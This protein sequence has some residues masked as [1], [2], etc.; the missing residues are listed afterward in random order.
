MKF[1]QKWFQEQGFDGFQSISRLSE[2]SESIPKERGVYALLI[3]TGSEPSFN[4]LGTGGHF[5][6]RNPNVSLKTL[7]SNWVR[8]TSTLYIGKAGGTGSSATL[9]SR[10]KQYLKFGQGKPV[11][12]WGGRLVWQI[13]VASEILIC[14]KVIKD[15][16]PRN[17]E[18]ELLNEFV[19]IY[20]KL[21][22]A[23]L[24]M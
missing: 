12:H 5:K 18:K 7:E 16:E 19:L 8:N 22:Y 20:G 4:E 21:P 1:D 24:T 6:G 2:S 9:H 10:L 17:V 23:N 14:W 15:R 11:G 3:P 13:E